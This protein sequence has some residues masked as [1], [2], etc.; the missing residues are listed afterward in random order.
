MPQPYPLQ[1]VL[2][3]QKAEL[4]DQQKTLVYQQLTDALGPLAITCIS[5]PDAV[6]ARSHFD[7]VI[8]PTLPWLPDLLHR[9]DSYRWLH[10]LS[11]G[12]EKIWPMDFDKHNVLLT[13]SSGVHGPAMSE[14]A[15]GAMLYFAKQF[16]RFH[17]QSQQR[18]WQ[19]TWL[20]EL[21]GSTVAILGLGHIGQ[22]IA[23]RAK[24]FDMTVWGT[25][26]HPR[27]MPQVDQVFSHDQLYAQLPEVDY[28]VVCLPLTPT[29][30]NLVNQD[31]LAQLKPGAV[32]ID[33]SRGGIVSASAVLQALDSGVLKGAALDVFEHQPLP[34]TS[35]L[36]ARS[37]I[38]LTPHVSGT[39]PYY[40][41]RALDIFIQNAQQLALGQAP[42]TPVDVAAGY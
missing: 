22:T 15:L 38:L 42:I 30:H 18:Q 6:E 24:A 12:V 33:I 2:F 9:L 40:L 34:E 32:L 10:F 31:V 7:A 17:D 36:W 26:N 27:P 20:D 41:E 23:Q 13:K 21:T 1:R 29:T 19:R 39:T 14:Y 37:D 28:L 25:L 5:S 11:A 35:P 4:I 16:G 8:T 3:V